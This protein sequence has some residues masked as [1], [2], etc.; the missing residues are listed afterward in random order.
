MTPSCIAYRRTFILTLLPRVAA[1]FLVLLAFSHRAM[2]IVDTDGDGV[3]DVRELIDKTDPNNPDSFIDHIIG[4]TCVHWNRAAPGLSNVAELRNAGCSDTT[5]RL[6]LQDLTGT[7]R[8]VATVTLQPTEQFDFLVDHLDGADA[9]RFG[10]LCATI[11]SGDIDTLDFQSAVYITDSQTFSLGISVPTA[12]ARTGRQ[13]IG[14]NHNYPTLSFDELSNAVASFLQISN[15]DGADGFG[16]LVYYNSEGNEIHRD[17]NVFV[18]AHGRTD[19]ATHT[20]EGDAVGMVEWIPASVNRHFRFA[21]NRY[22]FNSSTFAMRYRNATSIAASRPSGHERGAPFDT[23]GRV[24]VLELSNVLSTPVPVPMF[25]FTADGSATS[26][27]PGDLSIPARGTRHIILNNFL[28][29]GLGSVQLG[30]TTLRSVI[31]TLIEYGI[32][33]DQRFRFA[34]TSRPSSG[35]GAYQTATY[36]SFLGGCRL[37]LANLTAT[38]Q[39]PT[40]RATRFDGTVLSLPSSIQVPGN[41]TA[42]VDICAAE[43]IR[44]YGEVRVTP[45]ISESI[46]S[47]VVRSNQDGT[48]EIRAVGTERS[49]CVASISVTP[50]TLSLTASSGATGILTVTNNSTG[51]TARNIAPDLTGTALDGNVTITGNTCSN[52]PA[53]Q[54]CTIS[55]TPGGTAVPQTNFPISGTNTD[56]VVAA[57][58]VVPPP[59]TTLTASVSTL[60]L[61]VNSPVSDPALVGNARIIRIANTGSIAA[62]TLSVMVSGFPAGTSITSNTC[63]GTLAAGATCD[64]TITPGSNASL[65]LANNASTTAPGTEP[66]PTV[67]SV[68]AN[69]VS[70]VTID[71]VVLG[72]GTIW[73][74]GHVLSIDD[75]TPSTGSV[76]GKVAALTDEEQLPGNFDLEWSLV[77]DDTAADSITDGVTNSIS[78]AAP[79]G[80]YPAAQACL[81]KASNGYED[82]YLPAI[83]ELGRFVGVGS[84]AGCGNTNANLYTTLHVNNLA[85]LANG[86]Y[87]SS[88]EFSASPTNNGWLQDFSSGTQ[89]DAL[90]SNESRV[91]CLRVF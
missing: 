45:T 29:N 27:Q 13:F 41:G 55:F 46:V 51:V 60:A 3:D 84:D 48:L 15:D 32:G 57:I 35:F 85:G 58:S 12:H 77:F 89:T 14:F 21:Q 49:Q 56:A 65:D 54:S 64:I 16:D 39:T 33:S 18:P 24:T 5:V 79:V 26:S 22:Y 73:Q 78:L 59:M 61:S 86:I 82:W 70:T 50:S 17:Q 43:T 38:V 20:L 90:K 63:A 6:D 44:G 52:L 88:S 9:G 19:V 28:P 36:N 75:S 40:I 23:R 10:T 68:S 31:S 62:D 53:Q 87:W 30:T 37:R 2:A 1:V 72:Y 76:S 47:D 81:D 67:V 71:V 25:V 8:T 7:T 66:I 83:C 42:E 11:L 69:N 80:Q 91:R 34:T 4:K 74:G